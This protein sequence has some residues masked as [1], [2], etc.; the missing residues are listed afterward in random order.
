M[1]PGNPSDA[2]VNLNS[3]ALIAP[4][5]KTCAWRGPDGSNDG[6]NVDALMRGHGSTRVSRLR[7]ALEWTTGPEP[8]AGCFSMRLIAD[9]CRL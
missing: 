2:F 4:S 8:A 6:A 9:N 3:G 5:W 1:V 7:A